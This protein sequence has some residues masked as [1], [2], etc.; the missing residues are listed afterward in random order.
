LHNN[1]NDNEYGLSIDSVVLSSFIKTS[2]I[3]KLIYT[4]TTINGLVVSSP[5]YR[6]TA[7]TLLAPSKNLNILPRADSET[8]SIKINFKGLEK[9]VKIKNTIKELKRKE[10]YYNY[11]KSLIS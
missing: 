3:Y 1:A 6:V 9:T 11:S 8:G 10:V 2:E 4:V 5:T 7:E